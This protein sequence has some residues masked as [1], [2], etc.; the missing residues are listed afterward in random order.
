MYPSIHTSVQILTLM[1][2]GHPHYFRTLTDLVP[3]GTLHSGPPIGALPGR[4]SYPAK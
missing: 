1:V 4:S 3:P 2:D